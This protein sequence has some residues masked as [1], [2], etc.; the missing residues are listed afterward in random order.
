MSE[1]LNVVGIAASEVRMASV[2]TLPLVTDMLAGCLY[3]R[4]DRRHGLATTILQGQAQ[5]RW[6]SDMCD[7]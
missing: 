1:L 4:S 5:V 3:H 7:R 6:V 2:S